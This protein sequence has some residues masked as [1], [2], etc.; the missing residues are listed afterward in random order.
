MTDSVS[1]SAPK[2]SKHGA[3]IDTKCV[4]NS[5]N[6]NGL[7]FNLK[8]YRPGAP[9][10]FQ[11]SGTKVSKRRRR[12]LRWERPKSVQG[13]RYK[14]SRGRACSR[15]RP[16]VPT[17]REK[18]TGSQ[19]R[20]VPFAAFNVKLQLLTANAAA[21]RSVCCVRCQTSAFDNERSREAVRF[22]RS[23]SNFSF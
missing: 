8:G 22:L 18:Q 16:S 13:R 4:K 17:L 19:P 23:L 20:S 14:A 12:T 9:T 15:P 5:Q 10:P 2:G 11:F 21:K 3:D 6:L 7:T 1:F